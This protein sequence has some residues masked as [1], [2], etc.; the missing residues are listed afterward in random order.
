MIYSRTTPSIPES[1]HSTV[2][3]TGAPDIVRY[4]T[5]QSSVP[6]RAGVW[7]HTTKSFPFLLSLFL[8]LR[9]NTLVFKNNVLSLETYLVP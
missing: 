9:Q 8:A 6:G 5:G 7:L 1:G 3:Q 2:D 4:T